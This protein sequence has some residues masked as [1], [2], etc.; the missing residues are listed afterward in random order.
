MRNIGAGIGISLM[1][2][3]LARNSQTHQAAL[4]T[5]LTPYDPAYQ[6]W[7][8]TAQGALAAHGDPATAANQALGLLYAALVHQATLL[9]FLF[10]RVRG[11]PAVGGH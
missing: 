3:L 11:R 9:A 2:T 1:T 8:R 6:E 7:L 5:H 4:A 10:R